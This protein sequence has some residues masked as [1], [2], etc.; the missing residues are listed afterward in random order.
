MMVLMYLLL[1]SDL[2]KMVL[3]GQLLC[4]AWVKLV[5]NYQLL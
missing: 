4:F 1:Y 3:K 2:K 5:L